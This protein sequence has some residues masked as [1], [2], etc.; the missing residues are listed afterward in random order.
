VHPSPLYKVTPRERRSSQFPTKEKATRAPSTSLVHR[1]H[2]WMSPSSLSLSF[3]LS[4]V[5]PPKGL[6]RLEITPPLHAIVLQ[7]FQIPFEAVYFRNLSWIGDSGGNCDRRTCASMRRCRSCGARVVAPGYPSTLRS[8]T[9]SSS[10][11]LVR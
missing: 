10:L 6:R 2:S 4:S 9:L 3:S 8:T 5:W 7:S 1:P 11:T